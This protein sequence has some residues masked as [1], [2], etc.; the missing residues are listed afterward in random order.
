MAC[1][2]CCSVLSI[3]SQSE[4][5]LPYHVAPRYR[6]VHPPSPSGPSLKKASCTRFFFSSENPRTSIAS[7]IFGSPLSEYQCC[8]ALHYQTHPIPPA[9]NE[10]TFQGTVNHPQDE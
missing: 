2:R 6:Y 7:F 8:P 5:T 1:L 9:Q 4:L 3:A 10:Q